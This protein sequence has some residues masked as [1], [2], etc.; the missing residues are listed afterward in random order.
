MLTTAITA[1]ITAVLAMFGIKPTAAMLAGLWIFVK[2]VVV[3]GIFGLV[4]K[5]YK[6]RQEK[7]QAAAVE[8]PTAPQPD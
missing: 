2:I 5:M 3:M 8:T 7:A 4:G 6:A 1:A